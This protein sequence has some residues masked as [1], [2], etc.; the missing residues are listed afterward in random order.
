MIWKGFASDNYAG[1]HHDILK[2]IHEANI[3][4]SKAYGH[5]DYT[6]QAIGLF[7]KHF[8]QDIDVY[9]VCTGTAANVLSLSTLLKPYQAVICAESSHINVD[10]CGA[11]ENYIGSK[12]L[13]VPA[14]DGKLTIEAIQSFLINIGDQ[15]KVQPKVISITQGTELGTIYSPEEIKK[16]TNFAHTHNMYVHMDGARLSNAAASLNL[17][18]SAITKDVGVDVVCFGGTKDGMML[19]EAVIFFNKGL[20]KDFQYI[21]KQGMQLVSKMRFI[22]AQFIALLSD[23][24]W[25]KNA[26]HA[27]EMAQLLAKEIS[28]IPTIKIS[29]PVQSNAVFAYVD[30]KLIPILQGQYYF[31]VWDEATSEVRWM[32]SWDTTREDILEF[33]K[34]I[35]EAIAQHS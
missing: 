31:Y 34:F 13:T 35:N 9:F 33:V 29:K 16:I 8:G 15:H 2:A 11:P 17:S 32:T 4:H 18:F 20:S 6:K 21:R 28:T 5:D 7:K 25:L 30:P 27:N 12:L 14:P 19:G 23:N 24:L 26:Q 3:G 10:E 1:I 22:S